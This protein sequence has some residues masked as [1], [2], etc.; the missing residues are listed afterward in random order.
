MGSRQ[1]VESSTQTGAHTSPAWS[2]IARG[3]GRR[4]SGSAHA[5]S[6][7]SGERAVRELVDRVHV[8]LGARPELLVVMAHCHSDLD[9][10]AAG[11]ERAYPAVATH[12]GTTALGVLSQHGVCRGPG[13]VGV[14]ALSDPRQLWDGLEQRKTRRR[15]RSLRRE[16]LLPPNGLE[17]CRA[18][19]G[20]RPRPRRRASWTRSAASLGKTCP[21]Q[22]QPRG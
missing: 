12:A 2:A 15:P 19:S 4:G 10:V 21:S 1:S 6:R 8:E 17:S 13:S 22:R 3:R 7:S 14:L 16:A 9:G 20:S 11:L 5:T 18:S